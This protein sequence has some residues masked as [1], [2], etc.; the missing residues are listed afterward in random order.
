MIFGNYNYTTRGT[1]SKISP[2]PSAAVTLRNRRSKPH[3][4][5]NDGGMQAADS[6]GK[7]TTLDKI[8]AYSHGRHQSLKSLD[9]NLSSRSNWPA[10][11][12]KHPRLASEHYSAVSARNGRYIHPVSAGCNLKPSSIGT[13]WCEKATRL[14][15]H[16]ASWSC[17]TSNECH[18]PVGSTTQGT[19][20]FEYL[21]EDLPKALG[22]GDS[23]SV[24]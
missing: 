24:K 7:E 8:S 13:S 20:E 3:L 4:R 18:G 9:L 17:G 2:A 12:T 16:S 11:C 21:Q 1:G 22:K 19:P 6:E 10:S 14:G 5:M 15:V 23:G